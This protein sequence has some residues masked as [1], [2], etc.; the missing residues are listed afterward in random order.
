MGSWALKISGPAGVGAAAA[1]RTDKRKAADSSTFGAE[2]AASGVGSAAG[3]P[4]S[5]AGGNPIAAVDSLLTIQ[6]VPDPDQGDRKAAKH[7][8]DV[9]DLLDEIRLGL[10][11]GS[12]PE[13]RLTAL[14]HMLGASH[15]NFVDPKLAEIVGEIELRAR[16]ELAKLGH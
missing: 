2:T 4:A 14:V 13:H 3:G 12:I 15:Q 6:E 5:V 16:V 8:K 1:R 9:L 10:L 7:G 11:T